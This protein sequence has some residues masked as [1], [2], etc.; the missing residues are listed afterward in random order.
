MAR[1]RSFKGR[2]SRWAP[3]T[4]V[5]CEQN[6]AGVRGVAAE[7]LNPHSHDSPNS[8]PQSVPAAQKNI[9]MALAGLRH[10]FV[11]RIDA[12][13]HRNARLR[14]WRCFDNRTPPV[15]AGRGPCASRLPHHL[16]QR[17]VRT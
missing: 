17:R 16:R 2:A 13:V 8:P 14:P 10:T 12:H 15:N 5:R 11:V 6:D 4:A 3:G 1:A 7:S 9:T